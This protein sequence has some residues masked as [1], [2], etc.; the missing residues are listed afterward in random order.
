VV[1]YSKQVEEY[2][3]QSVNS[4]SP[5]Q[6]VIMLYDGAMRFMDRAAAAIQAKDLEAQNHNLQRAQRIITELISCLDMKQGG[7]V[8]QNLLGLYSYVYSELIEANLED[9]AVR[10]QNATRVL[11]EL[12]EGW[13]E[14]EQ[15]MKAPALNVVEGG[16]GTGSAA[17]AA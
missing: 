6:L 17:I 12:R 1:A 5:L 11:S 16:N 8:A 13:A 9:D 15:K 4:A 3:R 10:I 14:L 2:R 7:E